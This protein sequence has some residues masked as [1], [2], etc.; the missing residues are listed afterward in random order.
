MDQQP[1]NQQHMQ[2]PPNH[3]GHE[4]FDAHEVIAG[5]I[6]MLDQYQMYEPQNN[7]YRVSFHRAE[8]SK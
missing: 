4:L 2:A 1:I 6:S 7:G 5:I 3:G 8:F